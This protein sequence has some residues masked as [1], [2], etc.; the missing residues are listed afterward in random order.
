LAASR[1][2]RAING[3]GQATPPAPRTLISGRRGGAVPRLFGA[4]LPRFDDKDLPPAVVT[5]RW[6]DVVD[7][8]RRAAG[9]A[10]HQ[11]RNVLEEMVPPPVPLAVAS[12]SLLW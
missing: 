11:H 2:I 9:I 10:V 12:N 1:A 8:M 4:S 7:D 6:A 5:A 3:K